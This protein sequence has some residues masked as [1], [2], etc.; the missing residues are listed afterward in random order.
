MVR[1]DALSVAARPVYGPSG[2]RC[3]V[4]T[5]M[6]RDAVELES[7]RSIDSKLLYLYIPGVLNSHIISEQWVPAVLNSHMLSEQWVHY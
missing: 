6:V 4:W 2:P 7:K 1:D 5:H 3:F